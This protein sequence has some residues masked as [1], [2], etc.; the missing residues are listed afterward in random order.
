[1]KITGPGSS[2]AAGVQKKGKAKPA[3]GSRFR[4]HLENAAPEEA[5]AASP[6][7][8]T[9]PI[10]ALDALIGIQEVP[11]LAEEKRRKNIKRGRDMVEMLEE[12]HI[13]LLGG[14]LSEGRLQAMARLVA[15]ERERLDDPA[16]N[17]LLDDI[18]L[19]L[20]VELAKA[21]L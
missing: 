18:E 13:A 17:A 21:G 16:L 2:R 10:A 6:V 15:Q 14:G 8:A 11:S 12:I 7:S 19:R 5:A 20:R 4:A 1:M 3:D 9:T